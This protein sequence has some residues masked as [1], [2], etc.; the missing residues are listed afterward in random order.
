MKKYSFR[1]GVVITLLVLLSACTTIPLSDREYGVLNTRYA[2]SDFKKIDEQVLRLDK[3][4]EASVE[5]VAAAIDSIATTEWEKVRG[6]W[7]WITHNIKYDVDGFFDGDAV[8]SAADTFTE[9]RAVCAGYSSLFLEIARDLEIDAYEVNGYAKG[10]SYTPGTLPEGTNHAWVAVQID[11]EFHLFDPTWGAGSLRN[12]RFQ[13]DY[14]EVYFDA[15]PDLFILSHFP[16]RS[17]YQLLAEPIDRATFFRLPDIGSAGLIYGVDLDG[18]LSEAQN[19]TGFT[20]PTIYNCAIEP[21]YMSIPIDATLDSGS[22]YRFIIEAD[23]D[24]V[25]IDYG[26]GDPEYISAHDGVFDF[27]IDARSD[28]III[29]LTTTF[30]QSERVWSYL[31]KYAVE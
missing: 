23:T 4:E 7:T 31:L 24:R 5:T 10:Y 8:Y 9:R 13:W 20:S 15:P 30:T 25:V 2:G 12:R 28:E 1:I 26:S 6:V 27:E 17:E 11:E 29:S 14:R 21:T 19:G 18:V 22:T 3:E 16:E